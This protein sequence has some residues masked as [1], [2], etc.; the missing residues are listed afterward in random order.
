MK[1]SLFILF[2]L[3][4]FTAA[5]TTPRVTTDSNPKLSVAGCHTYNWLGSFR[6]DPSSRPDFV[7]PLNED[8]LRA[9]I[10]A[11]L[12]SKGAQLAAD[13]PSADCLVGYGVGSRHVVSGYY[14]YGWGGWGGWGWHRGFVG[15][16]WGGPYPY[17][18]HEGVIVVDLYDGA[19][20]QPIWHASA[21]QNI[22]GL[23]GAAAENK[24]N[25]AVTAIFAKYPL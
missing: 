18:Y 16:G 19:S 2:V 10:A 13:Q 20:R 11:N 21:D 14:P 23:T 6:G 5:C 12:Q 9:A 8:R 24:I 7:N 15:W 4:G 1:K 17:V 3:A 22:S 25:S